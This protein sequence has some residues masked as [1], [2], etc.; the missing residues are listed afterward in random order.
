METAWHEIGTATTLP[1][2]PLAL[3]NLAA[4]P[5]IDHITL[6]WNASAGA[7][8]YYIYD[9][10]IEIA[11]TTDLAYEHT[12][13]LPESTHIYTVKAWNAEGFSPPTAELTV[14]TLPAPPLPP[15][16]ITTEPSAD[17]IVVSWSPVEG[18]TKYYIDRDGQVTDMGTNTSY[19][20]TGLS[21]GTLH[22]YK[23][24][25]SRSGI[26]SD[27]SAPV[28]CYTLLSTPSNITASATN[29]RITLFWN[30]VDGASNYDINI[31]GTTYNT[32]GTSYA[33]DGLEPGTAYTYSV[34]A[35]NSVT[36]SL[37]SEE[38]TKTTLTG[39]PAT[40]QGLDGT[41]DLTSITLTW[42]SVPESTG[43]D[44][45]TDGSIKNVGNNTIY[46]HTGLDPGSEHIY[47][48]RARNSGGKSGWSDALAVS[49]LSLAP[50][51]PEN[52][53][54]IATEHT[55]TVEWDPVEG[56]TGYDLE[57]DQSNQVTV[58]EAV[59][60]HEGL[61]PG[62]RHTYRVRS[63]NGGEPSDWSPV[64][65]AYTRTNSYPVP[66]NLSGS[67]GTT[68]ITVTWNEVPGVLGYDLEADGEII[69]DITGTLYVHSGL[70][71]ESA[72]TYRV[73]TINDGGERGDWSTTLVI[74]TLPGIP[75]PPAN[76]YTV[77]GL[78]QIIIF[79]DPYPD[80]DGYRIRINESDP[81]SVTDTVYYHTDLPEETSYTYSVQTIIGEAESAW[82]SPV[83]ASTL[84][85]KPPVPANVTGIPTSSSIKLV[86]TITNGAT[87]YDVRVDGGEPISVTDAVYMHTGLTPETAYTYEVR[88]IYIDIPGDWSDPVTVW[89]LPQ[90]PLALNDLTITSTTDS[91]TLAWD[92]VS[93]A[94]G[95]DVEID[96]EIVY[97]STD[98]TFTMT[99]LLPGTQ[100]T[101]SV[102]AVNAG[103]TGPWTPLRT[104]LTRSG[105]PG[106]P[107]NFSATSTIN[108]ITLI[109]EAIDGSLGYDVKVNDLNIVNVGDQLTYTDAGLAPGTEYSYMVRAQNA[110]G[111]GD[112]SPLLKKATLLNAPTVTAEGRIADI[113]LTWNAVDN[114]LCYEIEADGLTVAESVYGTTFTHG[115]LEPETG[116]S[117][118]VK[119]KN[120]VSE[121]EWSSL[122]TAETTCPIL[123]INCTD[124]EIIDLVIVASNLGQVTSKVFTIV[125]N[126]SELELIDLCSATPE[127]DL[128][129]G[130]INGTDITVTRFTA[131]S[132]GIITFTVGTSLQ[133]GQVLDGAVN[134]IRFRSKINGQSDV[135]HSVQ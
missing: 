48:I 81:V 12:N 86:W 82:S 72:H 68:S 113:I 91:I 21:P 101:V 107:E 61:E 111:P 129:I 77:P 18:A 5:Y 33:C 120:A 16:N 3:Q 132:Q 54:S 128:D 119:A 1:L 37:W 46:I 13:L 31:G 97:Q 50:N 7:T 35:K 118:R 19:T 71:P 30:A 95:Y 73:R 8:K 103:G 135:M 133:I 28:T 130:R 17:K 27:W 123:T 11:Q 94:T 49:T 2:A 44:L 32:A 108:T 78:G 87:G 79:W 92:A 39:S 20:H 51:V 55:I 4:T 98:T 56:S 36:E 58:T 127:I 69:E 23:V 34:K 89:T 88:G 114:A 104:V 126:P 47:R 70:S 117:Y 60:A 85:N 57:I 131:D 99:G 22:T 83:I 63:V 24:R 10:G 122:I 102:R 124:G 106:V 115:N 38:R 14:T 40:P 64:L 26:D 52:L 41:P 100:H 25:S 109:W 15:D 74:S 6:T 96:N 116:H 43:Y 29:I 62:S 134:T 53:R 75:D 66:E 84:S 76:I 90:I 45:E 67:A 112:W 105:M 9:S 121:S 80:A 110:G 125:F 59:Y 42:N 65:I 93:G